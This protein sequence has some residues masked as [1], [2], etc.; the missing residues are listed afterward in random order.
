MGFNTAVLI[1]NDAMEGLK[2]D[3]D[4]GTAIHDAILTAHRTQYK[5]FS[6]A[7]H[8]NGG[9]VLPSQHADTVQII[10]VGGNYITTVANLYGC[11]REMEDKV[12]LTKRL[13]ASL[14]YRLVR[15]ATPK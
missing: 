4:V 3:P 5:G 13:A 12:E 14:G 11:W 7:Y 10:A 2:T 1:L 8:G 6:I 15:K 9:A